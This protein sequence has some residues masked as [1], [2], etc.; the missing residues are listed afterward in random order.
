M[1]VFPADRVAPILAGEQTCFKMGRHER[2]VIG[3]TYPASTSIFDSSCIF[4][5]ITITAFH[6]HGGERYADFELASLC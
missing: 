2:V 5:T 1:I 6:E 4:T 3:Q